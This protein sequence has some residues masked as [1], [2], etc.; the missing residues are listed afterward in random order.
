MTMFVMSLTFT[1][2]SYAS[3]NV[4][5]KMADNMT[6]NV[7]NVY[8]FRQAELITPL[9]NE[10]TNKTGIKVNLSSGKADKLME[11]LVQDGDSSLAD[12]LLTVDV[13]RLE[14]AKALHLIKPITSALLVNNVPS[15]LRDPENY[16]FGLSLRARAIFYSKERLSPKQVPSYESLLNSKWQGKI[17]SRAGNHMYNVSMLA[18][19]IHR[20]GEKWS[21]NWAIKFSD[22]LAMRPNGGDRDQIRK[23]ARGEC[24]IALANTYYY[25]ML[26]ASNSQSDREVYQK[27]GI[28][29]PQN[30]DIGS[31]VNI[32]G[33][34]L[35]SAAKHPKNAIK[36]I[37]FLTTK[38]AQEI[39]A[40]INYEYPVHPAIQASMLL[41]SWGKLTPDTGSILELTQYHPKA[42]EIIKR[43]SW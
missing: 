34:A 23:V 41:T 27:V 15:E 1:M 4:A 10:F 8:S 35:T 29:L 36:F 22:N 24:D 5:D 17:C 39:Y 13:A 26:S 14:K 40:N 28:V 25:G 38:E 16:W 43:Y 9:I 6:D 21:D 19:F 42:K 32:S 33:A 37:E 2:Y 11:R 12:V 30:L 18:S 31:H 7:V 3:D 20:Y